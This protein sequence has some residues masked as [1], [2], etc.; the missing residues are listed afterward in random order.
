MQPVVLAEVEKML[1]RW[2]YLLILYEAL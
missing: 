2:I 1:F